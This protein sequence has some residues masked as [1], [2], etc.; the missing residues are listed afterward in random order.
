[1]RNEAVISVNPQSI[2]VYITSH[3]QKGQVLSEERN[4]PPVC[5]TTYRHLTQLYFKNSTKIAITE[6]LPVSNFRQKLNIIDVLT[7][8]TISFLFDRPVSI[9]I[10]I[11]EYK[12]KN[13][14]TD[15]P[16]GDYR[17]LYFKTPFLIER[18]GFVFHL[19]YN[20]QPVTIKSWDCYYEFFT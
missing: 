15:N 19:P 6:A 12:S 4:T 7:M 3:K 14:L 18:W 11:N 16:R 2:K 17:E 8:S 1:M 13:N 9:L 5:V 10:S 20:L